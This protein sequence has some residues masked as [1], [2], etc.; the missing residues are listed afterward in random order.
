VTTI[1]KNFR[2]SILTSLWGGLLFTTAVL[3]QH[4]TSSNY[5]LSTV[6][7]DIGWVAMVTGFSF[8]LYSRLHL[9]KPNKMLLR[10]VLCCI[11]INGVLFHIPVVVTTLMGNVL[12]KPIIGRIYAISSFMEIVFSVQETVLASTYIYLFLQ[13]TKDSRSEPETKRT[14]YLLIGAECAVLSTDLILNALLYTEFYLARTMIQAFI[15]MLKLKVEFIVLNSLV[16]FATTKSSRPVADLW[17]AP[18][19]TPETPKLHSGVDI[20]SL[21]RQD[22]VVPDSPGGGMGADKRCFS[23]FGGSSLSPRESV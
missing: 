1:T 2:R 9:L 6:I 3:I 23:S 15:S 19:D 14:L 11:V 13:Y 8:V 21:S 16:K 4:Y 22:T 12:S 7:I 5:L 17:L 18:M 20:R 10:V